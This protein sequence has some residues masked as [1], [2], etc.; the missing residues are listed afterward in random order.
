MELSRGGPPSLQDGRRACTPHAHQ[1]YTSGPQITCTRRI[2]STPH[3]KLSMNDR[4]VVCHAIVRLF[5]ACKLYA[6]TWQLH[7]AKRRMNGEPCFMV[8]SRH[9]TELTPPPPNN[10]NNMRRVVLFI[11]VVLL[12]VPYYFGDRVQIPGIKKLPRHVM[13]TS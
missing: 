9:P 2:P 7:A 13:V 8:H 5:M 1:P 10:N 3:A 6:K 12:F 4:A 11:C